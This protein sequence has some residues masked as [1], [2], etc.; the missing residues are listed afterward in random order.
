MEKKYVNRNSESVAEEFSVRIT[1][2]MLYDRLHTLS[3]EYS[4]SIEF[5]VNIAI[6]RLINDVDFIRNLRKIK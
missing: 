2:S 1:N 6:E 4:V 3:V 5:L